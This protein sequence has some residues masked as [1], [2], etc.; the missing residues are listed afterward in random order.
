MRGTLWDDSNN[1]KLELIVKKWND[2][3]SVYRCRKRESAGRVDAS[4]VDASFIV[5][6]QLSHKSWRRKWG[7]VLCMECK[8]WFVVRCIQTRDRISGLGGGEAEH[9][10]KL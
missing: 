10:V 5:N 4:G 3:R 8:D 2:F 7:Q 6:C 1:S 9:C